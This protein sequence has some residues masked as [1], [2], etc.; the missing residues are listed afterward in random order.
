MMYYLQNDIYELF[1]RYKYINDGTKRMCYTAPLSSHLMSSLNYRCQT[2]QDIKND[3]TNIV[4]ELSGKH[5]SYSKYVPLSNITSHPSDP[6]E[7]SKWY[8]KERYKILN[9]IPLIFTNKS[10]I[11]YRIFTVPNTID[12][13]ISFLILSLIITDFVKKHDSSINSDS[14]LIKS[15][16]LKKILYNT[17]NG[18]NVFYDIQR[19]QSIVNDILN[20]KGGFFE[21]KDV[22][23]Q[24]NYYAKKMGSHIDELLQRAQRPSVYGS[25]RGTVNETPREGVANI[26]NIAFFNENN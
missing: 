26:P 16:D 15:Y 9:L 1:P 25:R 6:S 10:T 19:R 13:A 3:Y 14:S 12:K 20:N 11:E 23:I 5:S 4:Y 21:E 2:S 22:T 17:I 7:S 18:T 24:N 8:M